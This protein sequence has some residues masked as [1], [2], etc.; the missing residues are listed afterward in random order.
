MSL[1]PRRQS[2][3]VKYRR[4]SVR[5]GRGTHR[6][7]DG[8]DAMP[9]RAGS[10]ASSAIGKAAW[11][12]ARKDGFDSRTRRA[13]LAHEVERQPSKLNGGARVP[14]A[15]L[16]EGSAN[17]RPRGFGPRYGGSTPPPSASCLGSTTGEAPRSK[18][19]Q[20]GF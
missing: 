7:G 18:R 13:V 1:K 3:G 5:S 9:A 10:M 17:G 14:G 16:D 2:A 8:R 6:R 19:G 15:A 12:S 11:F 4:L 20:R